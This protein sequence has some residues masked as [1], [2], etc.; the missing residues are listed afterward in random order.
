MERRNAKKHTTSQRDAW[1]FAVQ[2][3]DLYPTN[4]GILIK[5]I[6]HNS[7]HKG[8]NV[9]CV[10]N[11]ITALSEIALT[12][13]NFHFGLTRFQFATV[14]TSDDWRCFP[15]TGFLAHPFQ[16]YSLLHGARA[17]TPHLLILLHW[18]SHFNKNFGGTQH[19]NHSILLPPP[20]PNSCL[21]HIQNT[22]IPS[23]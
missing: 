23:Q 22:I 6:T 7:Y 3:T 10:Y 12:V 19:W 9:W 17:S 14:G 1:L 8:R 13:E 18:A 5:P 2:F 21:S 20:T 11:C 16:N 4:T 15:Y